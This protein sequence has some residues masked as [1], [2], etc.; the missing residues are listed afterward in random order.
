MRKIVFISGAICS[1]VLVLACVFRL[2]L[3]PGATELLVAG[4]LGLALVFIPS[5]AKFMYDQTS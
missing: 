2:L 3:L 5:F 1:S 4:L